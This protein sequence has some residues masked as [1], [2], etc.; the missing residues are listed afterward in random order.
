MSQINTDII[1]VAWSWFLIIISFF[2]GYM[3]AIEQWK[4]TT[5][6]EKRIKRYVE[7][8]TK[9]DAI[10]IVNISP[11]IDLIVNWEKS[12]SGSIELK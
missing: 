2:L 1:K 7:I 8:E 10:K 5:E 6:E 9:K 12:L 11:S 3:F 4:S